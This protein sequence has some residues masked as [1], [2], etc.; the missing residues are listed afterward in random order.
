[1]M[2]TKQST[3]L[4]IFILFYLNFTFAFAED[5]PVLKS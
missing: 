3:L 4:S 2:P 5:P 1:M